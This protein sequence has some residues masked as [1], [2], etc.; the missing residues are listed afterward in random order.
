M[1]KRGYIWSSKRSTLVT[2]ETLLAFFGMVLVVAT[3]LILVSQVNGIKN[4][5]TFEQLFLSRDLALLIDALQA[6]PGD[7]SYQ[8][9]S[10]IVWKFDFIF[11]DKEVK[12]N[13]EG[14]EKSYP[15]SEG[16]YSRLEGT[17]ISAPKALIFENNNKIFSVNEK[18]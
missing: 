10:D 8:Y 9:S 6:S 3:Y 11:R 13:F 12:L 16:Q 17:K 5:T 1:S 4:D 18:Q 7:V 15:Y 2:A 14:V